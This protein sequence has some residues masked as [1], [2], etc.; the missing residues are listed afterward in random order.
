VL[1]SLSEATL[2][3][4]LIVFGE[5]QDEEVVASLALLDGR[6][7]AHLSWRTTQPIKYELSSGLSNENTADIARKQTYWK[8]MIN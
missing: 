5:E 6:V 8:V 7:Q 4:H 2:D 1:Y 3:C